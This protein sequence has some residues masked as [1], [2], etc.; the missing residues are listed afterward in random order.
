MQKFFLKLL[1]VERW[2]ICPTAGSSESCRTPNVIYQA[3]VKTEKDRK[4]YIG[5]TSM[6]FKKRVAKHKTD[7]KHKNTERKQNY[8]II[9]G[10]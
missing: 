7:F 1:F 8:L 2:L 6:E 3:E 4:T 9:S 10:S 5:L